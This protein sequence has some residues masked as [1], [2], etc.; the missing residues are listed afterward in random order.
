MD[1][2]L[3]DRLIKIDEQTKKLYEV[4]RMFLLLDAHKRVLAA[5]LFIK[6]E[7]KNVAEK[8]ALVYSSQDWINFSKGLA[9][10]ESSFNYEKR[11]YELKL[12]AFDAC[13]L[14]YKQEGAAIR[15]SIV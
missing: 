15:R 5:E 9:E 3:R 2:S 4:E 11:Q 10:A 12:K 1:D 7:G 6:A 8:E 14:S 13:Y